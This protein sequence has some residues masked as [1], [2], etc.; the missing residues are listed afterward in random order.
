MSSIYQLG[1]NGHNRQDNNLPNFF[2]NLGAE[3]SFLEGFPN[4]GSDKM[5]FGGEKW[6]NSIFLEIWPN[7]KNMHFHQEPLFFPIYHQGISSS[8]YAKPCQKV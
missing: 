4:Q 1:T 8:V 7:L 5:I 6:K 3:V 2:F